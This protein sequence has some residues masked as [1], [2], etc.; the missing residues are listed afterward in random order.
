MKIAF[1]HYHLKTGGVTTVLLQQ[2][3]AIS[4]CCRTLVLTGTPPEADFPFNTQVIDALAY[5]DLKTQPVTDPKT[6]AETILNAIQAH[7]GSPADIIHIHN[8]TLSKNSHLLSIL[9]ALQ[10]KGATLFLQCHDFAEDGRPNVFYREPYPADCHYGVINSR[11]YEMLIR[12]GCK[13][14]GLHRLT[15]TVKRFD[16][17]VVPPEITNRVLYPIRA[18]RRKNI[19]EAI[20]LSL[21]FPNRETLAIT[22]PPNSPIDYTAYEGWKIFAGDNQL[23]IDFDVGLTTDFVELLLTSRF[24]LTTSITEG[25]GFSFLE[26]WL[27]DKLLWGRRLPDICKDFEQQ[28]IHLNHLYDRLLVPL[29]WIDVNAYYRFWRRCVENVASLFDID[30]AEQQI[31]SIADKI[32]TSDHIDFGLLNEYFQKQIITRVLTDSE[33]Y[34]YLI[35]INPYLSAPAAVNNPVEL[36][37]HNHRQIKRNYSLEKY[38]HELLGTYRRVKG[39]AVKQKIDKTALVDGFMMLDRF[40]LLKWCQDAG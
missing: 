8:P 12:A 26:P 36:I 22:L 5:D 11:D 27:A 4:D 25:F 18:I 15:N 39:S 37:A 31:L 17:P 6:A 13:P 33:A 7:F 35:K 29:D 23:N 30:L 21:Y 34:L 20:L 28:G 24:I 10:A 19:G 16:T 40:S 14:E 9:S 1:I 38:R 2:A 32:A 3:Q